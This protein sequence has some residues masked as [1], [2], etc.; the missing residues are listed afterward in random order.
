MKRAA[1]ILFLIGGIYSI[2]NGVTMLILGITFIIFSSPAFYDMLYTAVSDG[3]IQSSFTGSVEMVVRQIQ[4]M[5][6]SMGI[7]FAFLGA[8]ALPNAALSFAA[9]KSKSKGLLIANIVF[10]F[11]SGVEVNAVG[12]IL[13]LVD[14]NRSASRSIEEREKVNLTKE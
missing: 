2:V 6:M 1:N 5:Y 12:A 11:L 3:T 13:A 8:F 10:S 14:N 4:L 7:V 9:R